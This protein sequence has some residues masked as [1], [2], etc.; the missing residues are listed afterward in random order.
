MPH[1]SLDCTL[2]P[3][4]CHHLMSPSQKATLTP[5][6]NHPQPN[7]L[8][9]KVFEIDGEKRHN[10]DCDSDPQTKGRRQR[11]FRVLEM[12]W[13]SGGVGWGDRF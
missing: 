12:V 1:P 6:L 3:R 5:S 8:S 2:G 13:E 7:H 4:K 10:K 9:G 11:V